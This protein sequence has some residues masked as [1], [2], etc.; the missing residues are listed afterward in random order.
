LQRDHL[1]AARSS[2]RYFFKERLAIKQRC[3]FSRGKRRVQPG[4][5]PLAAKRKRPP[6]IPR[7]PKSYQ[8]KAPHGISARSRY[9]RLTGQAEDHLRS[10]ISFSM[11]RLSMKRI[12]SPIK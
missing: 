12:A 11:I 1:P 5:P 3:G 10:Q 9:F 2:R 6:R 4:A 7:R 8:R